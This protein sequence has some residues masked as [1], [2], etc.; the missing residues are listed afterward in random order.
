MDKTTELKKSN[1]KYYINAAI[2]IAIMLIGQFVPAAGSITDVGMKV[3]FIYIGLLWSWST[4]GLIWPSFLGIIM[5]GFSGY[6][7]VSNLIVSGFGNSTN[8][9]IMLILIFSYFVT[10]SGV[11]DILVRSIIGQ[12]FAKGKPYVISWLFLTASYVCAFLISMTPA[13]IIVWAIL[14]K[15]CADVGYKKGDKYPILM[16]VGIA[17]AAL[18]GYSAVPYHM[19]A[20]TL[21]GMAEEAGYPVSFTSFVIV[22]FVIGYGS[23]LLYLLAMKFIFRPDV[24]KLTVGYD[25]SIKEK[26][27]PYQKKILASIFLLIIAFFIQ[28]TFKDRKSV[29]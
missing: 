26:M 20:A 29:V 28:S 3:L 5:L 2:G 17:Q 6:D 15:C 23:V 11:S 13:A 8:I 14:T 7:T 9:Y 24:S 21:V 19:P 12:K 4:V 16:I 18:M 27:T 25:F 1:T 10:S 22:A